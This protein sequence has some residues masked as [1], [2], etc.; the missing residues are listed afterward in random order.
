[1][2]YSI[3]GLALLFLLYGFYQ[4]TFR[5]VGKAFACDY[6]EDWVRAS[7]IGFFSAT[8]G[9]MQLVASLTAGLLWDRISHESVFLFGA[10][11]SLIGTMALMIMV[12]SREPPGIRSVQAGEVT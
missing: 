2:L 8:V 3:A 5:S 11:T 7:A 6:S 1:V 9:L 12:P 10:G 4:G